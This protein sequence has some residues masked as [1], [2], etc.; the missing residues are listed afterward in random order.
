MTVPDLDDP[1]LVRAGLND[2]EAMCIQCHT[3]PGGTPSAVADGLNPP[4][5]DLAESAEHMTAAEL[6]WVTKNGIKMTG[7]PA[8]GASH[9]DEQLWPVVAFL[10]ALPEVNAAG[11]ADLRE[12]A[13]GQGGHHDDDTASTEVEITDAD[14][15]IEKDE[16]EDHDHG[17]HEH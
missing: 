16:I 1:A 12:A 10:L 15:D 5:P 3:R 8:W 9:E 14:T 13:R 11:Y 7:M 4:P 17:D 2:F 6:F